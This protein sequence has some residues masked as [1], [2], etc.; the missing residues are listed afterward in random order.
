LDLVIPVG[1]AHK[2]TAQLIGK[3]YRDVMSRREPIDEKKG[4]LLVM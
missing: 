3:N 1:F 2:R 4:G